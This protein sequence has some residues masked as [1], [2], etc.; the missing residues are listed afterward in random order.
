[1]LSAL[2]VARPL[3]SSRVARCLPAR[4]SQQ[5]RTWAQQATAPAASTT[6]AATAG[7]A[8]RRKEQ[9]ALSLLRNI[10]I[11]AHIDSG[12]TTLTERVLYYTGRIDEMHECA[13]GTALAS[14]P[15]PVYPA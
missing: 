1:M 15:S 14:S 13:S 11:S 7:S 5:Q 2:L 9:Q 4:V 10:G 6:T 12:K 8:A 3:C